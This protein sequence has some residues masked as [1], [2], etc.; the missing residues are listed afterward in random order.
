MKCPDC[1]Y[2]LWGLAPPGPCP[3]C[4]RAF[5]TS[6]FRFRPRAV[7]FLCPHC[8]EPYSGTDA[9]GLP[10][11]RDFRCVRCDEPVHVDDMPVELRPGVLPGQAMAQKSPSWPRRGEVGW[12]RA[13]FR[14]LNDSM[15][16]PARVVRGLG[17]G[18]VG[19]AIWFAIIVHGLATLFQVASFMLLIAV[20]SM[21]FGGG[22]AP[23]V[24]VSMVTVGPVFFSVVIAVAW[25]V[26][27]V[28][29]YGLLTH[30]ILRLT[31]PTDAGLGVTLRTL[32]YAQGPMILV[33]IPCCGL[34][35]GWA[36]SIWMA[37]SAAIMLTVAQGVSGGRAALAAV[38][39]PLL[40]LLLIFAVYSAVVFF[41]LNS[42]RNFTPGPVTIG[43]SDI[44]QAI[45]DDAALYEG[46]PMHVLEVV[47][48]GGLNEMSFIAA[49]GNTVSFPIGSPFRIDSL[50]DS[51][52]LDRAD[53]LRNDEPF[54]IFG[55]LLFLHRGVDYTAAPTDLWLAVDD[56]RVVQA[57]RS[58]GRLTLNCHRANGDKMLIFAADWDEAIQDQNLL[59][60]NLGLE[61]IPALE[62]LPARPPIMADP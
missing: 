32:W 54:Y 17:E 40:F 8:R 57:A 53:R 38:A 44:S 10:T 30:G 25:V 22:P 43:A 33:A 41:S 12:F 18:G 9:E 55:D 48:D 4:G 27:G 47:S 52:L 3:E 29:I 14:T 28:F 2:E 6:E 1:A 19:S 61:P 46:G 20:F 16:A 21:V 39:P 59:R 5:M 56:P 51:Q 60:T 45:L 37:V 49:S 42:V 34:Y 36:F 35:F 24:G 26:V 31:G 58:G 23:L 62:D 15:F 13:F 7:R 50:T 11:P